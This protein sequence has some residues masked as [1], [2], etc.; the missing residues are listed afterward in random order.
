[1]NRE[2]YIQMR[3]SGQYDF[4]WFYQYFQENRDTTRL[5]IDFQS[6]VQ[7]FNMYFTINS[8]SIFEF[9]DKKL[10]VVKIE[11]QQGKLIYI[12]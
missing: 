10:D 7:A 1:M 12:N 6:F 4:N 5:N 9:I 8:Q 3:R 11:D 2:Q